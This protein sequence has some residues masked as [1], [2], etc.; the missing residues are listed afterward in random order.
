[1][2]TFTNYEYKHTPIFNTEGR[3]GVASLGTNFAR[4]QLGRVGGEGMGD[5]ESTWGGCLLE[6]VKCSKIDCGD[7]STYLRIC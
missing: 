2:S 7:G 1:M 6:V 5:S 4:R 3:K